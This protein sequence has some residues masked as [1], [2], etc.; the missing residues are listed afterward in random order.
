MFEV[1]N[2]SFSV[3]NLN[4]IQVSGQADVIEEGE[5]IKASDAKISLSSVNTN[6]FSASGNG[7]AINALNTPVT[8]K[9]GNFTEGGALSSL[10]LI[11]GPEQSFYR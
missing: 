9:G 6:G 7:G 5:F 4:L 2:T 10:V 11:Y 3:N 8:I 1:I